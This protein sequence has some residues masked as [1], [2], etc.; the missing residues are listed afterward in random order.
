[1][2]KTISLN[3]IS[4][5]DRNSVLDGGSFSE[6]IFYLQIASKLTF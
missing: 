4:G 6:I 1:M 2:L 5:V 3:Q